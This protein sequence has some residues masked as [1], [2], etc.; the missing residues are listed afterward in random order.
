MFIYRNKSICELG[1]GYS[2]LIGLSLALILSNDES[3]KMD[4]LI[5]DGN[6]T[7]VKS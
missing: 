6:Q 1:A 7:C 2:G 5:T 4:I 3:N